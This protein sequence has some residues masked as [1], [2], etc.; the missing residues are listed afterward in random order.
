M[1]LFLVCLKV[2]ITFCRCNSRRTRR[3]EN[4]M[5]RENSNGLFH[6]RLHISLWP[7]EY[8]V[9]AQR[10]K[11]IKAVALP[12]PSLWIRHRPE[13]KLCSWESILLE[14]LWIFL[15]IQKYCDIKNLSP[16]TNKYRGVVLNHMH[17]LLIPNFNTKP[18]LSL[19]SSHT[20]YLFSAK[21]FVFPWCP[22][23]WIRKSPTLSGVFS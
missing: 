20:Q 2:F 8:V 15:I 3:S 6:E 4:W 13:W 7:V 16:L 12:W 23:I 19:A 14:L 11:R 18:I 9:R 21:N 10:K 17:M 22:Q 5:R 1:F